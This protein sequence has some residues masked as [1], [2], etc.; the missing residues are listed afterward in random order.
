M[1]S[2]QIVAFVSREVRSLSSELF[3]VDGLAEFLPS[4]YT[5]PL[6]LSILKF[7]IIT[8]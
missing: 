3:P 1:T 5:F 8:L 2:L 7:I 6:I 4:S